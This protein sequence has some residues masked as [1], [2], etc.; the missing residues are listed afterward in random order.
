KFV[1]SGMRMHCV[2]L[3]RLERIQ[4]DK[5]HFPFYQCALRHPVRRKGSETCNVPDEHTRLALH[6][7]AESVKRVVGSRE[8]YAAIGQ[9]YS[10]EVRRTSYL[11]AGRIHLLAGGAV[12]R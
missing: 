1:L 4:A 2:F 6:V 7:D 11:L 8:E 10:G 9:G 3:P 12:Q 5:E